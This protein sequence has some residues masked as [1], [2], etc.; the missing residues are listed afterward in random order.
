M[1]KKSNEKVDRGPTS[2]R[3]DKSLMEEVQ[4]QCARRKISQTE[5]IEA[6]LRWWL[7]Y[8]GGSTEPVPVAMSSLKEG[9]VALAVPEEAVEEV[10]QTVRIMTSKAGRDTSRLALKYMLAELEGIGPPKFPQEG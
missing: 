9:M 6:G 10:Y 3:I 8:G 5:A 4:V 2:A 7:K 1:K